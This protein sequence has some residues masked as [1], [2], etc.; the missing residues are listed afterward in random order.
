MCELQTLSYSGDGYVVSCRHCG[1][2]RIMFGTSLLHV[3]PVDFVHLL[4]ML[5][6]ICSKE[7]I[8]AVEEYKNIL[9]PTP[10]PETHIVLSPKEAFRLLAI[11]EEADSEIKTWQLLQLF[12]E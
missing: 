1:Y 12:E 5:R 10:Y 8:H 11:L 6:M 7:D 2:V 3:S 4:E 9:V